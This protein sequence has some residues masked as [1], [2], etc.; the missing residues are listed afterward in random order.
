LISFSDEAFLIV[1]HEKISKVNFED[2]QKGMKKHKMAGTR[3]ANA[4][5]E[6]V[7]LIK[8]HTDEHTIVFFLT[9]GAIAD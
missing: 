4:V 9:D 7:Q 6:A 1:N 5:E 2:V 3:G 8:E